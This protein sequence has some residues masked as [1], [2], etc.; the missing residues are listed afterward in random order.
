MKLKRIVA[1]FLCFA[2]VLTMINVIVVTS[3]V[4]AE[5]Q[6]SLPAMKD[7]SNAIKSINGVTTIITE[8]GGLYCCG[9]NDY[10]QLGNGTILNQTTFVKVMEDVVAVYPSGNVTG[11]IKSNGDLYLFGRNNNGQIGI[12]TTSETVA[13]PVK[14]MENVRYFDASFHS[15]LI[16]KDNDLYC[17]G[18]NSDGQVGNDT[19]SDQ[20]TPVKILSNVK[21]AIAT[22]FNT[23]ALTNDGK[24]YAWG[25][26]SYGQLGNEANFTNTSPY[27]VLDE[28]SDFSIDSYGYAVGALKENGDLYS[29]GWHT[30][31]GSGNYTTTSTPTKILENVKKF[32]FFNDFDR[33]AITNDGDLYCWGYNKEG[34]VGVGYTTTSW[35]LEPQKILSNIRYA[36]AHIYSMFAI[37]EDNK[38]YSWGKNNYGQLGNG[39]Q[40]NTSQPEIV[41]Q[42]VKEIIGAD[43][44]VIARTMD[45][46]IYTWGYGQDGSIG[47]GVSENSSSPVKVLENIAYICNTTSRFVVTYDG[48]L[49]GW[50]Y[51]YYGQ[52]GTGNK[53][54]Q[55]VPYRI[56]QGLKA[57]E[58]LIKDKSTDEY[59]VEQVNKY[60]SAEEY[61]QYSYIMES[62]TSY[63]EKL[64]QLSNLFNN[65]G[66]SDIREGVSYLS[67]TTKY[68]YN[69]LYLTT[70]EAFCPYNFHEWLYTTS[71]G[72]VARSELYTAGLIF[73]NELS[74]WT[75]L[76]LTG[77][78]DDCPG[79]KKNK[80]FLKDILGQNKK[81]LT[82]EILGKSSKY[83]KYLKNT[84]TLNNVY[85]DYEINKLMDNI[86]STTD[87]IERTMYQEKFAEKLIHYVKASDIDAGNSINIYLD[88]DKFGKALGYASNIISIASTTVDDIV[89]MMKLQ[90]N[91]E[92]YQNNKNFLTTIYENTDVSYEMRIAAK[93]LLNDI[94]NGYWNNIQKIIK[95][96]FKITKDTVE[97]ELVLDKTALTAI[98]E[99]L[100]VDSFGKVFAE[101]MGTITL[102][103]FISNIVID[104][105]DFVKQVA[106][107][108]GYAELSLLYSLKLQDD[109]NNFINEKNV[110][111]AWQFFEDYTILWNLRYLGEKQYLEMNNVKLFFSL[112]KGKN[113]TYSLKEELVKDNIKTLED[114]KFEFDLSHTIPES[115]QYTKKAVISCPVNVAIY[116]STGELIATLQDGIESDTTNDY[117]R[118]IVLYNSYSQDYQKIICLTTLDDVLIE[119]T[120]TND[121]LVS[122]QMMNTNDTMERIYAFDNELI[123]KNTII[124][125]TWNQITDEQKYEVDNNGDGIF[126]YEK[127]IK[128]VN[129]EDNIGIESLSL[130]NETLTIHQGENKALNLSI[131][132]INTTNQQIIWNSDDDNIAVVTDGIITAV[133]KGS[134]NITCISQ[135]NTDI[136]AT[137]NVN[138]E[139]HIYE[140]GVCV[141]CNAVQ[142]SIGNENS[143]LP[144]TDATDN[145]NIYIMVFG[146]SAILFIG[147]WILRKKLLL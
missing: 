118:F 63:E 52:L 75:G 74:D 119:A 9:E 6:E 49:Y 132:P 10:G 64:S 100:G 12:G 35:I 16:T 50:G 56:M 140:N 44:K 92:L 121:G 108:Q 96:I 133:N 97:S 136:I 20:L 71:L 80:Q 117:G 86:L 8:N 101:A 141:V 137:C 135:M 73:N 113:W 5:T 18:F 33:Y 2:M 134:V 62:N 28:V 55:T 40:N 146:I 21:R 51:N 58:L 36:N 110:D 79:A 130:S 47:N 105:G 107:T 22:R 98:E 120:G 77:N 123:S 41:M 91:I 25:A 76:L 82:Q 125:T 23:Y 7:Y 45:D 32:D 138:I 4:E 102:A 122:M 129:G 106:Y 87:E 128:I 83:A 43:N 111:N 85:N 17:W 14:V 11:A 38:L 46:T 48:D 103:T 131:N 70:D 139:G 68:R 143:S 78:I 26:N 1:L 66:I 116:T 127:T 99:S 95:D 54:N 13:T 67:N 72:F 84:L 37:S 30:S 145:R 144:N 15:L 42:N 147:L 27:M 93:S 29:W 124:Q 24:L 104:A 90:E 89:T 94:N 3:D 114:C 60:T 65:Y 53:N 39:T 59:I 88:G 19:K 115:V 109:R 69:Y 81:N 34:Q 112:I 142:P 61:A 126:D 31:G 57:D